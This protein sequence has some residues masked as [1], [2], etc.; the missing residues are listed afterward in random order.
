[1]KLRQYEVGERF[2]HDITRLGG[3]RAV[4]AAW[5]A[6]EALPTTAELNA[7]ASWLARVGATPAAS[8]SV[9]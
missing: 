6:P 8:T 3:P 9:L 4:D 1:M 7:P 5:T 2:V